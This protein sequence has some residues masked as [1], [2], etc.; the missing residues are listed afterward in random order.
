MENPDEKMTLTDI[1]EFSL[2]EWLAATLARHPMDPVGLGDDCV[3]LD[4]SSDKYL[5]LTTDR[6]PLSA[7]KRSHS[8]LGSLCVHQNFSDIICKGGKPI[9]LL[10]G[11]YAPRQ[12]LLKDWKAIVNAAQ[13]CAAKYE[14]YILGGDTKEAPNLSVVGCA[15]G[16]V[17]KHRFVRRNTASVGDIVAITLKRG[18][19][20]GLPWVDILSRFL[21]WGLSSEEQEFLEQQFMRQNLSLPYEETRAATKKPGITAS[22]DTSDGIGGAV[23][24]LAKSNGV[25]INL[26]YDDLFSCL[27][28]RIEPYS[29]RLGIEPINFVFTPGHI[30]ENIFAITPVSFEETRER[31]QNAGGDLIKIGVL[32][33]NPADILMVMPDGDL[34]QVNL[35][36]NEGFRA[37]REISNATDAWINHKLF[38]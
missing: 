13:D 38:A 37:D 26:F 4:I 32:T 18:S 24:L 7:H 6:V 36:F 20:I 12:T 35:F 3:V 25:G 34:Q 19:R 27:D 14:A 2:H 21:D 22:V 30:W 33:P 1:G 29:R 28:K 23:F 31:V 15:V 17:E 11:T 10:L 9:G 5:L 8:Y 16:T